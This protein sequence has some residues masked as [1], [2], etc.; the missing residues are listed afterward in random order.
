VILLD[1]F[2]GDLRVRQTSAAIAAAIGGE[3][4]DVPDTESEIRRFDQALLEDAPD[5]P[6][7]PVDIERA[8][9]LKAL[10]LPVHPW[11]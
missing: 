7:D 10:G 1:R 2:L 9:L 11:R 6:S 8:E 3:G 5:V 4:E